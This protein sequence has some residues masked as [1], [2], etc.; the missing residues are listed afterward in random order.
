LL[1]ENLVTFDSVRPVKI[2]GTI[3]ALLCCSDLAGFDPIELI[4]SG[5]DWGE[6][7][8]MRI[9]GLTNICEIDLTQE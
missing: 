6:L 8:Q 3:T 4:K 7:M 5:I 1:N 9:D 2:Q